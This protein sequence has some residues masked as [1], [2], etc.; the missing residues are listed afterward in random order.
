MDACLLQLAANVGLTGLDVGARGEPNADLAPLGPAVD[1]VCFEP[2]PDEC[3]RLQ[4]APAA[5][6][7][8]SVRYIPTALAAEQG[9]FSLHLYR[10]RGCSSKFQADAAAAALFAR[11]DYYILDDAISIP[12]MPL[13]QAVQQYGISDPVFMKTDVQ[14]M[15]V[16]CFQGAQAALAEC[17]AGVRAEVSFFPIYPEQPL[18]AEVDQALRPYGFVPMRWLELHEWRRTTWVKHPLPA[19]GPLPVSRG[20][21]IH[22]DV[23][24][25]LH[26]EWMA[27]DTEAS[28]RR[29]ARLG[30]IAVC[31][32]HY[33]HALAA[34]ARAGEYC[35]DMA[36]ADPSAAV[37]AL[38][39]RQLTWGLRLR[40][41]AARCASLA[42][43]R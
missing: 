11:Q 24:Y 8:R 2:D 29:L 5:G 38:S 40:S 34:F 9:E 32:G 14:G 20:Q 43:N 28:L 1:M 25:L 36:G 26:P 31:Y 17:L 21:M 23:L 27:N 37:Q 4:A 15:E 33:D 18:F 12:A 41:F 3:A 6:P 16:E 30:L 13:D 42:R 39:R 10:Q 22:G 19:P 35:N 7:W